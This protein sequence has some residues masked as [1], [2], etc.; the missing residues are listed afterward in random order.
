MIARGRAK[1]IVE[2]TTH[3]RDAHLLADVSRNLGEPMVGRSAAALPQGGKDGRKQG[4][5][6]AGHDGQTDGID[7]L[8]HRFQRDGEVVFYD[9]ERNVGLGIFADVLHDILKEDHEPSHRAMIRIEG[10]TRC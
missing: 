3:F 4:H 5:V 1:A 2:A 6:R 10:S 7:R 9:G 8:L